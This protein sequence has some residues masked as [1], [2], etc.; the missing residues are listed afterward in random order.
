M[1]RRWNHSLGKRRRTTL[2]GEGVGGD[3]SSVLEML[4]LKCVPEI[5]KWRYPEDSGVNMHAAQEKW[6]PGLKVK[7]WK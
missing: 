2:T 5:I 7:V 3:G 6:T 4:S 1:N